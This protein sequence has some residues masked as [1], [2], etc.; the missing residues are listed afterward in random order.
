MLLKLKINSH[1][2]IHNM[3]FLP[4]SNTITAGQKEKKTLR[5]FC[6]WSPWHLQAPAGT[7]A[8]VLSETQNKYIILT[9][10][11]YLMSFNCTSLAFCIR[12]W[13]FWRHNSQDC[14]T[15]V[16]NKSSHITALPIFL[17]ADLSQSLN[18]SLGLSYSDQSNSG[19]AVSET[20]LE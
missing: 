16:A 9:A 20:G 1:A 7:R 5:S 14:Q 10:S 18:L 11:S 2:V 4:F 8:E 12:G 6:L 15:N 3:Y 19:T 13:I 17:K